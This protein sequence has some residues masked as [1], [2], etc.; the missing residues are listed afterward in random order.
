MRFSFAAAL[1]LS[2]SAT[3]PSPAFAQPKPNPM[4]AEFATAAAA[5]AKHPGDTVTFTYKQSFLT[6]TAV[7]TLK[8]QAAWL[9]AHPTVKIRLECHTDDDFEAMDALSFGDTRCRAVETILQKNGV[10]A[11]RITALSLGN[12]RPVVKD[13]KTQEEHA[14]NRRV[15]TVLVA[16]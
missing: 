4:Q 15:Q 1:C 5:G 7:E 2:L 14:Q 6:K 16:P 12:Q 3:L 11:A 8:R 13:A 9:K 10:A